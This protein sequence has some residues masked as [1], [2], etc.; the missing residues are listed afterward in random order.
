[1]ASIRVFVT[2]EFSIFWFFEALNGVLTEYR[3]LET[4]HVLYHKRGSRNSALNLTSLP[5][6][7]HIAES[8][9][10][11]HSAEAQ[12]PPAVL[13]LVLPREWIARFQDQ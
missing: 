5:G 13:R 10:R 2:H 8:F 6:A 12:F 11:A 7:D 3:F 9:C 1:M 4:Y